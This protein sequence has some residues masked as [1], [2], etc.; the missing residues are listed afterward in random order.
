MPTLGKVETTTLQLP[1]TKDAPNEADKAWVSVKTTLL[2]GDIADVSNL[3]SKT[4]QAIGS[5]AKL[6]V[7]WNFTDEAGEKLPVNEENVRK[8]EMVDF[9][10]LGE[11]MAGK[12]TTAQEGLE[13][14]E[15]KD[16][17]ASSTPEAGQTPTP[18][19]ITINT[20]S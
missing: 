20:N 2:L 9:N 10:F 4:D 13:D 16:S 18:H 6:I 1:S 17:S 7:D 3:E 14:E 19:Q 12:L 8:L 15:K 5:L 11:W